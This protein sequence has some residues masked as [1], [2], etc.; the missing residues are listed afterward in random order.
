MNEKQVTFEEVNAH[1]EQADLSHFEKGGKNHF[2]GTEA[3]TNPTNVL[4][5]VCAIYRTV[6]PFLSLVLSLPLIPAS[7]KNALR[8]F[9]TLMDQLCPA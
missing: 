5:S 2:T 1:F 4:Q 7:W 9:V 3:L 8:T 6:R